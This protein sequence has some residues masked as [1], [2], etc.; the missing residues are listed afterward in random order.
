[1]KC[2][3]KGAWKTCCVPKDEGGLGIRD[4]FEWNKAAILHQIW[5][6]SHHNSKSLWVSWIQHCL[7]GGKHFWTAK[8]PYS[9][10]WN[11]RKMLNMRNFAAQFIK[12]EVGPDSAVSLW[13]DPW[14]SPVPLISRFGRATIFAMDSSPQASV[15][16][17]ISDGN[18]ALSSSNDMFVRTLRQEIQSTIIHHRDAVLWDGASHVN[19]SAVWQ[20]IRFRGT[21]PPWTNAIWHKYS[22]PR[23][24]FFMW[25]AFRSSLLTKDMM[26]DYGYPVNPICILCHSGNETPEHLFSACPYTYLLLRDCPFPL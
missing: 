3:Y 18:W 16:S 12:F 7:L 11:V 25:L 6:V 17:I 1:M 13:H 10:P 24:D 20:S 5:R 2:H 22:I 14:L 15:G 21:P 19:I 23:C 8:I 26:I 9:C 4:L